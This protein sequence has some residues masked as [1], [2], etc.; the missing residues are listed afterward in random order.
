[1]SAEGPGAVSGPDMRKEETEMAFPKAKDRRKKKP[2]DI[3]IDAVNPYKKTEKE[4]ASIKGGSPVFRQRPFPHS[5]QMLMECLKDMKR[6]V[7][8]I[9]D[10][11]L[12]G[13]CDQDTWSIDAWFL[14]VMPSMLA[15]LRDN[16]HG[17]PVFLDHEGH[18]P[19]LLKTS[20]TGTSGRPDEM[21]PHDKWT[22]ILDRMIFLLHEMDEDTCSR[23]NPYEKAAF[24]RKARKGDRKTEEARKRYLDYEMKIG[25][26]RERCKDEFFRLFSGHFWDLWD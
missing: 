1:M 3:K 15:Y 18:E 21:D 13:F 23:K 8:R 2:G 26:Y 14:D 10:R 11:A 24:G 4:R 9:K 19:Q 22:K 5:P 25:R 6:A 17:S 7:P 16:R 20:G 12:H